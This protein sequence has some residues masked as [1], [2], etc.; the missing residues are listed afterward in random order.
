MSANCLYL[1]LAHLY[2]TKLLVKI[3]H[4]LIKAIDNR[5]FSVFKASLDVMRF[6]LHKV[7]TIE[8][9]SSI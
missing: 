4:I 3:S 1:Q 5:T 7:E 9:N 2:F 6:S 8:R